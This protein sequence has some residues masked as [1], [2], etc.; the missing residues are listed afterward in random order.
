MRVESDEFVRKPNPTRRSMRERYGNFIAIK[1]KASTAEGRW[2][3]KILL[4]DLPSVWPRLL[5]PLVPR[6]GGD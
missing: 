3:E 6:K 5:H 1:S 2:R 4:C